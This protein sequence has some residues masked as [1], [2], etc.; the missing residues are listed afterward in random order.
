VSNNKVFQCVS[1]IFIC[2]FLLIIISS[3]SDSKNDETYVDLNGSENE[4]STGFNNNEPPDDINFVVSGNVVKD[5]N[6]NMVHIHLSPII[7][8]NN[9][10]HEDQDD[11]EFILMENGK[12]KRIG[13]GSTL[14][15]GK[16]WTY[17]NF[18]VIYDQ[19]NSMDDEY[20]RS[21]FGMDSFFKMN[22]CSLYQYPK[23]QLVLFKD[24]DAE[25]VTYDEKWWESELW[26]DLTERINDIE[27]ENGG[28][29]AENPLSAIMNAW[30]N[31][32]IWDSGFQRTFLLVTDAP[33]HQPGDEDSED[34]DNKSY[35][36]EKVCKTLQN[37]GNPYKGTVNVV[38]P[39]TRP[40]QSYPDRLEYWDNRI[41]GWT[42][43]YYKG[44]ANPMDLA[45]CTGG[46][47]YDL[48]N[49]EFYKKSKRGK[50]GGTDHK[51][52]LLGNNMTVSFDSSYIN[53]INT[54]RLKVMLSDGQVGEILFKDTKYPEQKPQGAPSYSCVPTAQ[55]EIRKEDSFTESSVKIVVRTLRRLV[56]KPSY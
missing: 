13:I 25:Y 19:S 47:W 31:N 7:D 2:C 50:G 4:T 40:S 24:R 30:N 11:I 16:S 39:K 44:H 43:E 56:A 38:S 3:C 37:P 5:P 49:G 26:W 54:V 45:K 15:K 42:S 32:D 52:T 23:V 8:S 12:E 22:I 21:V 14:K 41:E 36:L 34:H 46:Q 28:N 35:S 33:M 6:T 17:S 18:K 55:K 9:I 51:G 53:D 10:L 29:F 48:S 1:L 20:Y 27:Y